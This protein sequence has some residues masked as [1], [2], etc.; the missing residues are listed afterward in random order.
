MIAAL[1]LLHLIALHS[2]GSSNPLG[3]TAFIDKIP[4][5]PYLSV[6]DILGF[7]G[8]FIVLSVL[9]HYAPNILGHPDNYI[10]ANP[11]VTP[12]HIVPEFY[13]LFAY[14]ILRSIPDKLLGVIALA[15]SLI[16]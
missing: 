7:I 11:L 16:V 15:S 12:P 8:V 5:H 6:K 13:F 4:F 10:M 14:A 3:V 2:Y 1:A 9:V